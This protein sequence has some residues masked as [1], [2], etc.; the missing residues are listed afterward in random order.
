MHSSCLYL[1][2]RSYQ[3]GAVIIYVDELYSIQHKLFYKNYIS[4]MEGRSTESIERSIDPEQSTK[5][6]SSSL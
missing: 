1:E 3:E 4:M 2:D 5:F 6:C